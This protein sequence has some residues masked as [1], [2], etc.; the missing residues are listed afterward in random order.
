MLEKK[1]SSN[2]LLANTGNRVT[3]HLSTG[4]LNCDFVLQS[5]EFRKWVDKVEELQDSTPLFE[6]PVFVV[7]ELQERFEPV[8]KLFVKLNGIA[9]PKPIAPKAESDQASSKDEAG[10]DK[11]GADKVGADK[12]GADKAGADKAGADTE[13]PGETKSSDS[14]SDDTSTQPPHEELR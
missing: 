9:A 12:A 4:D 10:A 5:A 8:S 7:S 1:Q 2:E 13:P 14:A 11:A 6:S 3:K